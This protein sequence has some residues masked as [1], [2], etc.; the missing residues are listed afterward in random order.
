[1]AS[2]NRSNLMQPTLERLRAEFLEMPDLRVTAEQ[3]Q[4]LCGIEPALCK[5]MLDALVDV[6]FLCVKSDGSY[7]RLTDGEIVDA[8]VKLD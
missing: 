5:A 2:A 3:A 1:M 4:R 8:V 7:A 6:K